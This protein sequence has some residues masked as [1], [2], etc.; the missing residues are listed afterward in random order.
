MKNELNLEDVI[1][2]N[3]TERIYQM[4]RLTFNT[5][6]IF[7]PISYNTK[8]TF[9]F[10]NALIKTIKTVNKDLLQVDFVIGGDMLNIDYKRFNTIKKLWYNFIYYIVINKVFKK[11][12]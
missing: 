9:T 12:F 7:I 4:Y 3:L 10:P 11:D 6:R 8:L 5:Y 1:I 2:N